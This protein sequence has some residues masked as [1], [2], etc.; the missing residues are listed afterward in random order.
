MIKVAQSADGTGGQGRAGSGAGRALAGKAPRA[1]LSALRDRLGSGGG[2]CG[3][4]AS[5]P[6][7]GC[8]CTP[9]HPA[10]PFPGAVTQRAPGSAE[11]AAAPRARGDSEQWHRPGRARLLS[12]RRRT[13]CTRTRQTRGAPA[14]PHRR[15][16]SHLPRGGG[17]WR[18]AGR[19][20]MEE[21][22]PAA[23]CPP[24]RSP[25]L[26]SSPC[27][28]SRRGGRGQQSRVPGRPRPPRPA[29]CRPLSHVAKNGHLRG[30]TR[31]RVSL[32]RMTRRQ[33]DSLPAAGI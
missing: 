12:A 9:A 16:A 4:S 20:G 17:G 13:M 32:P 26:L 27:P 2:G 22:S 25:P 29:W 23:L 15:G 30:T 24:L 14:P 6:P 3:R 28:R 31:A 11:R 10:A 8:P 18:R 19:G 33:R 21:P 1:P 5:P 7:P